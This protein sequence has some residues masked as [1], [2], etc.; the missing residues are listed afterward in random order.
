MDGHIVSA[1][2]IQ[3]SLDMARP[4]SKDVAKLENDGIEMYDGSKSGESPGCGTSD[5]HHL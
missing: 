4:I 1:A 2:L 5:V 3:F